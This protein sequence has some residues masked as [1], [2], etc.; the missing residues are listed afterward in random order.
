[1]TQIR[2]ITEA[3][4]E[5][6]R[7]DWFR[8]SDDGIETLVGVHWLVK[9]AYE[10]EVTAWVD[11]YGPGDIEAEAEDII[12]NGLDIARLYRVAGEWLYLPWKPTD[13]DGI[14]ALALETTPAEA[15]R[16]WVEWGQDTGEGPW[17]IRTSKRIGGPNDP[18]ATSEGKEYEEFGEALQAI[19]AI[20]AEDQRANAQTYISH[21]LVDSQGRTMGQGGVWEEPEE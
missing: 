21:Y 15:E 8:E 4:V 19:K 11:Y 12:W 14:R 18:W 9:G 13:A 17:I 7:G 3:E 6:E 5:A 16:A 1:M 2:T 20:W 10:H